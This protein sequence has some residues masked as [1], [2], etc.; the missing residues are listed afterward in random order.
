MA[1]S[2]HGVGLHL[3]CGPGGDSP[4]GESLDLGGGP[5]LVGDLYG[6]QPA[7]RTPQ[8]SSPPGD[9][10][11]SR[12]VAKHHQRLAVIEKASGGR[13]LWLHNGGIINLVDLRPL[14]RDGVSGNDSRHVQ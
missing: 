2:A 7:D 5:A 4:L 1:S 11:D 10:A 13:C 12:G 6:A 8:P 14:R 3:R 9:S